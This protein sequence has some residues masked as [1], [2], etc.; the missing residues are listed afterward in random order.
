MENIEL[1]IEKFG[2]EE[3]NKLKNFIEYKINEIYEK[4]REEGKFEFK[5]EAENYAKKGVPYAAKMK[6]N[7]KGELGR[8]FFNLSKIY[9]K[10]N[11]VVVSGTFWAFEGD[12]IEQREGGSWGNDYRYFY[13]VENGKLE[14]FGKGKATDAPAKALVLEYLKEKMELNNKEEG[15][16][17]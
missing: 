2:L 1:E 13:K 6:I 9:D 8:E 3:L 17:K 5:F 15:E 10:D 4:N 12:I 16:K 11:Y 14:P 7:E